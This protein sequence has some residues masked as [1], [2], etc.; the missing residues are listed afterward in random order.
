[1]VNNP[2]NYDQIYLD[3]I[4]TIVRDGVNKPDRTS[5]GG[6]RSIFGYDYKFEIET[7]AKNTYTMPFLQL[8]RFGARIAFHELIWMLNGWTHTDYLK[9]NNVRIWDGNTTKEY[10][11]KIGKTHIDVNSIGKGYG[12]QFR[13]FN[14][15]DQ[16]A[17]VYKSLMNNSLG[18]RHV[19]SLWNPADIPDMALE[20]CHYIYEFYY[21]NG[22]LNIHQHLRSNDWILGQPYNA[23]FAAMFLVFMARACDMEPGTVWFTGTDVHMYDNQYSLAL[24]STCQDVV[25]TP[26]TMTINSTIDHIDDVLGLKEHDVEFDY[27][28]G[29][30]L[31][32]VDMAV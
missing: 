12:Y 16:L 23:A 20:P 8:R 19:I 9:Q 11:E 1:M 6:N 25:T 3:G 17:E 24:K 29:P 2:T 27:V 30:V 13:N 31:E 7:V 26:A 22:T 18:R 5:V 14:G 28:R 4:R 21:A 15:V 10:L 32:K